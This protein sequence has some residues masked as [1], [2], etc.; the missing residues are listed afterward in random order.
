MKRKEL[1]IIL[2]LGVAVLAEG[3]RARAEVQPPVAPE[4]PKN[5]IFAGVRSSNYGIK[6]FPGPAG[7]QKAIDA[8]S[9]RF[10]G[11]TRGAIWI[12]GE[13]KRPTS[14]RLFF[15]SDG[16]AYPNIEF[17]ETDK[18]EEFLSHFDKTGTKVFLQ[19]EPAQADLPT[20]ID[21][22]LGRYKHHPCVIGFGVD[23]EWYRESDKPGWGIPVDD[24]TARQWEAR[25]KA[26]NPTY[27]LFLKHWEL[28]WMPKT[29]RG[30][31]VF[32]DDGQ[33]VKSLDELLD[34]FQNRWADHFSPSPVFFQIGYNSDKPW[35]QNLDNPPLTIGRAIAQRVKQSCG[36]IWVDFSLRE[37]FKLDSKNGKDLMIGVKIYEHEGSLLQLFE[38]WRLIRVNTVFVSPALAAQGQFRELAR[39]QGISVF[40][41]LPVFSNPEELK[42]DPGLYALTDRGE[43]AKDDWVEFVCPTRQDYR[44][45][46][47]DWIKTLVRELD[48]DGIS[49]DFIRYFVFWE[50]VA[51]ER[52]PDSIANSCFDRSCLDRFQK[53]TGITLPKGLGEA[54][55][56]AKWIMA[57]HGQ[58]WAEWKCGII[59]SLVRSIAAEARAIKPKLKVNIHSVPW[60][61][62]DFGGAIKVIA[63]QDLAALAATT[64]MI[65]PMCYWHMLK[66]KPPWIREVVEDVYSK[67]KGLVVPSI[68]VTNAYISDRL[69]LEEF[70]KALDEALRP[71]SGG[72]IFWNWDALAKEPE[73]KAAVAARL[74][75][76]NG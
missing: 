35:W 33:E 30:D 72:V 21:V 8:M 1:V 32:I 76:R 43:K 60:R 74:R 24:E 71:P 15:P 22:V 23:V 70:K 64:D 50:M 48:P 53:D 5:V 55:E 46:R 12:V 19:V 13:L 68:Q 45:R 11:S 9:D 31:I 3:C 61:E 51:P 2:V 49:L 40:L 18:H 63:G 36:I 10:P 69:S 34:A 29:Y 47:I 28:N 6:P 44:S 66:R 41:I 62:K 65:S 27:R 75:V 56:A 59:T 37:V 52:T 73:K 4:A 42:K 17:A 20:L 67:T 7:W 39:K 54:A 25:V 26:H 38:E 16:K 57:E 14:C 58:D